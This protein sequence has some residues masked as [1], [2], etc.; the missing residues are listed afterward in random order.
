[1]A[2]YALILTAC[3]L[4]ILHGKNVASLG[5]HVEMHDDLTEVEL[6]EYLF[7]APLNGGVVRAVA[8]D[9]FFDDG[10]ERGG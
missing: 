3:I 8:R 9:E 4:R 6:M 5:S 7:D 10:A 1:L 2:L